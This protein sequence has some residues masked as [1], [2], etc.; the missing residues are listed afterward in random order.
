MNSLPRRVVVTGIGVV[1]PFGVGRDRFWHDLHRGIS[2]ARRITSF[3]AS[4]MPTRFWANTPE[5]DDELA[6]RLPVPKTA[7]LLTR[8][9]KM[10]LVAAAEA[11]EQSGLD[12]TALPHHR[13][14]LSVG[15]SGTGL[16]DPDV[17]AIGYDTSGWLKG[18][19]LPEG[20]E[21]DFWRTLIEQTHPL[22][23]V[24]AIPNA[25][26]AHLSIA[27]R[28]QGNCQTVTTACTSGSQALGEAFHR[29]R[30][31]LADV[32]IAGGADSVTNPSSMLSFSL[33]GVLSRNNDD[34]ER[35]SRPFDRDRDGFL[36]GEGAAFFV[37][38]DYEHCRRRGGVPLAEFAGYGC[39]SDAYRVTDEPEDARGS[40][41]AMQQALD[42]AGLR[43]DEI[44]YI[45]AHGTSTRMNDQI[46][47][48]AIKQVFGPA[49]YDIPVS[50][51]K[52]MIGHLVAGAGAIEFAGSLLALQHQVVPPTI[53]LEHPGEGCDLDYVPHTAR[54]ARLTAILSN[55]FGF[56]GQN[57][58]LV[59][60]SV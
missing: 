7:K 6:A 39:T 34:F 2:A 14:G 20:G 5:T 46:E 51:N 1:S 54:D 8:C 31:G 40:R 29:I 50:S 4:G 3:E 56:G 30:F 59:V 53:N 60:R 42:E 21:G 55:S 41:A 28:V 32:M 49:A 33:L 23:A 38:E 12:F 47:T 27:Y 48:Y 13:V 19:P 45:N 24:K 17:A 44:S 36:L 25:I 10:S 11:V 9:A 18:R 22:M 16:V 37:L 52:S 57:S 35:A 43:P 26:S 15:A 58:C